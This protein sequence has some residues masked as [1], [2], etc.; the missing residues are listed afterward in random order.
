MNLK[1]AYNIVGA[2]ENTPDDELKQIYKSAAKKYHP[3]IYSDKDKFKIINEAYQLITDHR[4]HPEKY[5]SPFGSSPFGSSPFGGQPININDLFN[6]IGFGGQQQHQHKIAHLPDPKLEINL[7]FRESI[8]GV[9]KEIKYKKGI[10]CDTCKGEGVQ[11]LGNGCKHCNGMGRVTQQNGPMMF[12]STCGHCRG[13][14]IK[15]NKCIP[16]KSKGYIEKEMT[17]KINI[18]SGITNNTTL[19]VRGAGHYRGASIFGESLGDVL[20]HINVEK[21][22]ELELV[23]NDVVFNL[24]LSLLE[25]LE[26]CTKEV[27]TINGT[28]NIDVPSLT[29]NRDE[30][31]LN[32]LGVK[33]KG[34]NEKIILA[35]NYPENID[36]LKEFLKGN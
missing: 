14:N 7:S 8:I 16:C 13:Q 24:K 15:S 36:G 23:G 33:D 4:E 22:D 10:K 2:S 32:G 9:E 1:E 12:S 29:K 3:D 21:D 11:L 20:L 19:N 18:P 17:E 34:G 28:Q 25:A 30:I 5:S 35:I 31:I 26:G 6:N 27:K